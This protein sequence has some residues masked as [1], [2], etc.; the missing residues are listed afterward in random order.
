MDQVL[1]ARRLQNTANTATRFNSI[2]GG[3][4][5]ITTESV[6]FRV[7]PSSGKI[8]NLRVVLETSPGSGKS[9]AFTLMV[10]SVAS[11]LTVTI[12][13]SATIGSDLSNQVSV[14]AGQ[15]VT[16]RA[17]PTGTP[18]QPVI[19]FTTIFTGDTAKESLI[20]G[21]TNGL[22]LNSAATAFWPISIGPGSAD[23][24]SELIAQQLCAGAGTIK[25][26]YV[27]LTA[28]PGTDPDAYRFTLRKNG[29]SQSLTTTITANDTTGNDTS[30]S[31]TVAAGDLLTLFVEPLNSPSVEPNAIWGVT[32]VA[33]ID[34]ES[35]IVSG[36]D[37]NLPNTTTEHY[38]I[39]FVND[40]SWG[41]GE[42]SR[43][44]ALDTCI[45]RN[46]YVELENAPG[47]GNSFVFSLRISSDEPPVTFGDGNLSVTISDSATTGNDT[48]NSE[49]IAPSQAVVIQ[50]NPDSVP[51]VGQAKWGMVMFIGN[52]ASVNPGNLITKLEA[53]G[54]I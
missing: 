20:M 9:W 52:V 11:A 47:T 3:I 15:V 28:D 41:V 5:W 26:L 13:D 42:E 39:Q 7:C 2:T 36:S 31:F 25:N 43:R 8:K 51:T 35:L 44:N 45:L 37:D 54:I 17:I 53:V 1:F 23:P 48:S 30:N 29:V 18:T 14:T 27:Q 50:A 19:G 21:S 10:D 38:R 49:S 12:S 6:V 40:T 22:G 32:F 4:G 16:I 46:L 33:D 34:G 24:T